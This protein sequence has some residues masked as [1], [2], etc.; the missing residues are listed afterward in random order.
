LR[1]SDGKITSLRTEQTIGNC[2]RNRWHWMNAEHVHLIIKS[3]FENRPMEDH[4]ETD[5]K[6][7][8]DERFLLLRSIVYETRRSM[9]VNFLRCRV[10]PDVWFTACDPVAAATVKRVDR[11]ISLIQ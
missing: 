11:S 4:V 3:L 1:L 6:K 10:G 2:L 9:T 7:S 8:A 5:V